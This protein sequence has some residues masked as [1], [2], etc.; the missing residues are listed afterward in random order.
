M[1][2]AQLT[3]IIC[4]YGGKQS[5]LKTNKFGVMRYLE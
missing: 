3:I 2:F 5:A 1:T 4:D